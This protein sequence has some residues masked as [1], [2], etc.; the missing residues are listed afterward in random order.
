VKP[1]IIQG[2][3]GSRRMRDAFFRFTSSAPT[4]A[5]FCRPRILYK[6]VAPPLRVPC[7]DVAK[8]RPVRDDM[9]VEK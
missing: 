2:G 7:P 1:G 5:G 3:D 4:G 8:A 6:N 9:I